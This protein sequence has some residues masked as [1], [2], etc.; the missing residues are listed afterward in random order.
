VTSLVARIPA[1]DR[2]RRQW[3]KP[4]PSTIIPH[5]PADLGTWSTAV[6]CAVCHHV[7]LLTSEALV[8]VGLSPGTKVLDLRAAAVP[9]VRGDQAADLQLLLSPATN[10]IRPWLSPTELLMR[11]PALPIPAHRGT[12]RPP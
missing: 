6:D 12:E 5:P 7:A 2:I 9:G 11:T 4:P 8:R 1:K 10:G 3:V